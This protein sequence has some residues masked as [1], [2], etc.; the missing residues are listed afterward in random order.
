MI[1][2]LY[3]KIGSNQERHTNGPSGNLNGVGAKV[4]IYHDG[5]QQY[6]E[7]TP[8]RGYQSTMTSVLY[9]GLGDYSTV[10]SIIIIWPDGLEQMIDKVKA[11]STILI[12]HEDA[13]ARTSSQILSEAHFTEVSKT[14]G[15][16]YLHQEDDFVDFKLQPLL[17][18]KH[19]QNGPGMAVGDINGDGYEDVYIGGASNYTG[20][21][22]TQNS[23]GTFQKHTQE[24][25][26]IYEDMGVLLFDAD[27]DQDLDLYVVSGG[28]STPPHLGRYVDRIYINNGLG[29][30]TK[31]SSALPDIRSSGSC[32]V[33]ADYDHDGDIDLFVGGRIVPGAYPT[34]PQSYLLRN[35]SRGS[36]VK[37]TEVTPAELS[38]VGMVTDARWTD[39]DNDGWAD[40]MI[41]GEFMPVTCF[42]NEEGQLSKSLVVTHSSGWWQ[43]ITPGDYDMDGDMD[44][45]LGNLGL[46]ARYKTSP[47]EPLCV[48]AKDFDKNGRIDPILCQYTNGENHIIHARSTLISQINA[49][50]VRFKTHED[51]AS[52]S[53][54]RS[55][56]K[57]ELED[58]LVLKTATF[59]NSYLENKGGGIFKLEPLAS[60]FQIAPMYGMIALDYNLDGHLDILGGGNSFAAETSIGRYDAGKGLL[61]EGD[62]DEGFVKIDGSSSGV[63]IP[64][65]TKGLVRM[66][67]AD[68][69]PI[70]VSSR[71]QNT[72]KTFKPQGGHSKNIIDLDGDDAYALI[73][74]SDGRERRD[75][76]YYGQ[77]YLSH[78]SRVMEVV[79]D[80][81]TV[82]IFKNTGTSRIYDFR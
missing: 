40:L 69:S 74:W 27:G 33:G 30:F 53:F 51:Y 34:V 59:A 11:D 80:V 32:V 12:S 24:L 44:Y 23:E 3:F 15:L 16:D 29:T 25:D 5:R 19:S 8:Y 64:G 47:E 68:N 26:P 43:S 13:I 60:E 76:F 61:L 39:Y 79:S 56:L 77:T 66:L 58:A 71:N 41:V 9:F 14:L 35:D 78:S 82:E 75:E 72:L 10:D 1:R 20:Q 52:S 42:K 21:F 49:M 67:L 4:S 70:Y 46:N 37:F 38:H 55:F 54:D 48:Y 81:D 73:K 31:N 28:S 63:H 22:Y 36:T 50:R 6:Q 7:Y 2:H 65:D 17:P 62:G 57:E 18:H 45:V